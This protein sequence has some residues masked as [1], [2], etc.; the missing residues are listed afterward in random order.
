MCSPSTHSRGPISSRPAL[1]LGRENNF[2]FKDIANLVCDQQPHK[3]PKPR[4]AHMNASCWHYPL[5][6]CQQLNPNNVRNH[7]K[8]KNLNSTHHVGL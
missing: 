4:V 3:K 6:L 2:N 7:N 8:I 5:P 1:E